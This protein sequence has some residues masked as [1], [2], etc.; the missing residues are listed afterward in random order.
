MRRRRADRR[1]AGR[2]AS[3]GA[4]LCRAPSTQSHKLTHSL[5]EALLCSAR[6]LTGWPLRGEQAEK[7]RAARRSECDSPTIVTGW[8]CRA[9]GIGPQPPQPRRTLLTQ[10]REKSEIYRFSRSPDRATAPLPPRPNIVNLAAARK[11]AQPKKIRLLSDAQDLS[12]RAG[13]ENF[14]TFFWRA[15]SSL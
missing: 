5:G 10:L 4:P 2:I 15:R 7:S 13:V 11:S 6:R 3:F 12:R 8:P 9:A 14:C 1:A